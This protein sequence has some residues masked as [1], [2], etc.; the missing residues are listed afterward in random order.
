VTAA[1]DT[2]DALETGGPAETAA[3]S[4]AVP[5]PREADL[6]FA[7]GQGELTL[8]VRLPSRS[9]IQVRVDGQQDFVAAEWPAADGAVPAY[10]GGPVEPGRVYACRDGFLAA[11]LADDHFGLKLERVEG[12]EVLLQGR[13]CSLAGLRPGQ[14]IILDRHS[15]GP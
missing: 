10:P 4:V 9:D 11:W 14:E 15:V 2:A 7:S 12:A 8:L 1:A 6:S 13:A 5:C 3:K